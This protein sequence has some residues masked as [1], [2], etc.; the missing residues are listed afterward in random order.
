MRLVRDLLAFLYH[1]GWMV[2]TSLDQQHADALDTLVFRQKKTMARKEVDGGKSPAIG[3]RLRDADD[4]LIPPESEFLI[5]SPEWHNRLR[6]IFDAPGS[7]EG[8]TSGSG[9]VATASSSEIP[10]EYNHDEYGLLIHALKETFT[11]IDYFK[12]GKWG[13]DSFEFKL[14][15]HPWR[16][17]DEKT[18]KERM[19]VP[20]IIETLETFGW[21]SYTTI[22][23]AG[24]KERGT[25]PWYFVRELHFTA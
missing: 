21:T 8:C 1:R 9:K 10:R 12:S 24:P 22:Q 17:M 20:K 4:V 11:E 15:G 6:V 14:R 13:H 19:L 2:V 5:L 25:D 23:K 18:V 7:D 3:T 16:D